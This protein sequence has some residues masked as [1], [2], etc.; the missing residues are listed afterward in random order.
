MK[1]HV[2]R[3]L[4]GAAMLGAVLTWTA[5]P[6]VAAQGRPQGTAARGAQAKPPTPPGQAKPT[7]PAPQGKPAQP[8]KPI[9]VKPALAGILQPLLPPNTD[10][11]VASQ[12]FQNLGQFVA[13]VRVSDNL[14]IPFDSLRTKMVVDQTSLGDAIKALKPTANVEAE[15]T[16]AERQARAD[17]AR[18]G[19]W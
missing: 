7:T 1:W 18:G 16:R 2:S 14:K 6:A 15:T 17:I 3:L 11:A 8:P 10:I 4:A 13:A 19:G 12:G 5:A 9:V